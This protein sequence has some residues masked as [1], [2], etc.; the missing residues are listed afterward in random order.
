MKI[1]Y[2]G[3]RRVLNFFELSE[4]DQRTFKND[5]DNAEGFSYFKNEFGDIQIFEFMHVKHGMTEIKSFD[6]YE[7]N[8]WFSGSL[9]ILNKHDES[10]FKLFTFT[11]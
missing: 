7:S 9:V 1:K 2:I 3:Q 8:S 5:L 10:Y 11:T 4:T 6:G